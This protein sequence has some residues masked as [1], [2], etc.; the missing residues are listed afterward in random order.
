MLPVA[1][2]LDVF[3][4]IQRSDDATAEAAR[5]ADADVVV[6]S[7]VVSMLENEQHQSP[8]ATYPLVRSAQGG[9]APDGKALLVE[10][11]TADG[12]PV[13]FALSL[14]DVQHFVAFLLI[15][16]GRMSIARDDDGPTTDDS[17]GQSPPVP[18]T[19]IAIGQPEGEEG[20]LGIAVG[21]AEL[22]F[23]LPLS[24]FDE[25]GRTL[26]TVSARPNGRFET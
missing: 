2:L 23:S 1:Q 6:C 21:Q 4:Y 24:V 22:V 12:E 11:A 3:H 18:A 15:S 17:V 9:P 5:E 16:V 10:G 13:R 20:Y 19:S 26:L 7:P 8:L 25:L 14:T